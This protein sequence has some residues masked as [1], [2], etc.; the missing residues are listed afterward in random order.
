MIVLDGVILKSRHVV[1][2]ESLKTGIR[3][4]SC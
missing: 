3:T 2:T 4:T 1:R